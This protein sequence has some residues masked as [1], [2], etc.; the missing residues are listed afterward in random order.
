MRQE[1]HQLGTAAEHRENSEG[2]NWGYLWGNTLYQVNP[3]HLGEITFGEQQK[4]AERPP[5]QELN[6]IPV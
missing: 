5:S 2:D 1:L 3:P 6:A 4:A